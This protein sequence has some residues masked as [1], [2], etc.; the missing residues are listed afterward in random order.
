MAINADIFELISSDHDKVSELFDE[1]EDTEDREEKM[2]LLN[3]LNEELETHSSAEE[4]TV[5]PR[6]EKVGA[7]A[8]YDEESGQDLIQEARAEHEE[9]RQQLKVLGT[10][11]P[12]DKHWEKLFSEL[13]KAVEH[14]VDEEESKIFVRMN[15]LFDGDELERLRD[16]FLKAKNEL[17]RTAA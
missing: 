4:Q 12:Q 8:E 10:M 1:I 9:V 17:R 2:E 3:Q 6:I 11:D 14:H 7:G 16:D 13:R 15:R 5:Y